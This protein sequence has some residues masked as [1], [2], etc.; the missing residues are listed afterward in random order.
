MNYLLVTCMTFKSRPVLEQFSSHGTPRRS[1]GASWLCS[2]I[3]SG[4]TWG[5][6]DVT[7][8]WNKQH[9]K[10]QDLF[11]YLAYMGH[12]YQLKLFLL[13]YNNQGRP[14]GEAEVAF[15]SA[16]DAK[17]SLQKDRQNMQVIV[18]DTAINSWKVS[19]V[20][21]HSLVEYMSNFA[22]RL[23]IGLDSWRH[24]AGYRQFLSR[25]PW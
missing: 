25:F 15:S 7:I 13:R 11:F 1:F 8:T 4:I 20:S 3:V 2:R 16:Q 10:R 5:K 12:T 22:G 23:I 19:S 6:I 24:F 17:R 18:T 9:F 21:H 14:T